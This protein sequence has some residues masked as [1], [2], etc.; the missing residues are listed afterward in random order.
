MFPATLGGLWLIWSAKPKRQ[1]KLACHGAVVLVVYLVCCL[2][3]GIFFGAGGHAAIYD[4]PSASNLHKIAAQI[5]AN[6]GV[7]SAVCHGPAILPGI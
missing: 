7:V 5:Y 3:Y 4:Y 2:Q 6:G 1:S